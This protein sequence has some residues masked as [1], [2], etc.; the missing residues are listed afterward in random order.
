[1]YG[2][3]LQVSPAAPRDYGKVVVITP[4]LETFDVPLYT[5]V[6]KTAL[7]RLGSDWSLQIFYGAHARAHTEAL[8]NCL[9]L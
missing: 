8:L 9:G 5:Y 2:I 3:L 4:F 7:W 6:I 1:M